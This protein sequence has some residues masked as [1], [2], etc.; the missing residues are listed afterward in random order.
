M[1]QEGAVVEAITANGGYLTLGQLYRA[2]LSVPGVSWGTKTP[3]ASMRRIVQQSPRVF[4][5]RP[6]LWGLASRKEQILSEL[7][8]S[9]DSPPIKVEEFNHSY[10]Q[11]LLVEI[12]NFEGFET[13]VPAQDRNRRYLHGTLGEAAG[14]ETCYAFTYDHVIRRAQSVDVTWFNN[15]RFPH[16]F[17]EVE[18]STEIY[19]SLL[20]FVEFQD[21]RA[22][23]SIVAAEERQREFESKLAAAAFNPIRSLVSFISY[24]SVSKR[25]STASEAYVAKAS[26]GI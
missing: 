23:C 26:F 10:Y 1:T 11:G 25:H 9:P 5:I 20:K 4:R 18:H 22:K 7:A 12:G 21:F 3:F 6:G 19:N 15:R 17:F 8:I 2:A 24:E 14:I 13:S 16:A